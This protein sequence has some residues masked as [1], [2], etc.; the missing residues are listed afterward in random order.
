MY[1]L[2]DVA[3]IL[4]VTYRTVINYKNAG[5]FKTVKIGSRILVSEENLK[6]FLA[7]DEEPKQK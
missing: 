4:G 3:N 2:K 7:G 5:K 6:K 1:S